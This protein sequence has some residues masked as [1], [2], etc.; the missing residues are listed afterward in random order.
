MNDRR[1]VISCMT[2]QSCDMKALDV[3]VHAHG[4]L[5]RSEPRYENTRSTDL[6]TG[7]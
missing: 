1:V 6:G 4:T 2:L 7:L 3:T 5:L